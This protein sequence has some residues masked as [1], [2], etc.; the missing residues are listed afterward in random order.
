MSSPTGGGWAARLFG[1][2]DAVV[3]S[4]ED[5]SNR[6]RVVEDTRTLHKCKGRKTVGD[7]KSR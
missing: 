3:S 2:P 7:L 4:G 6:T 1:R 5:M